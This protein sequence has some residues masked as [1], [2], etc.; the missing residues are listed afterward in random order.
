MKLKAF[1]LLSPVV[2]VQVP[3][4]L[5]PTV[6]VAVVAVLTLAE[7]VWRMAIVSLGRKTPVVVPQV[8]LRAMAVQPELQEAAKAPVK[9]VSE[10]ALLSVAVLK[11]TPV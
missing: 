1:G 8:P 6:T 5:V 3:D 2:T 9:P 7:D 10:T 11:F 4:V